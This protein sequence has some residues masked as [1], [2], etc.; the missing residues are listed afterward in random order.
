VLIE[1]TLQVISRIIES[2]DRSEQGRRYGHPILDIAREINRYIH[3]N[4]LSAG[5]SKESKMAVEE[6]LNSLL[7][8][9][10]RWE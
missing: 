3:P 10:F 9:S 5:R 8:K 7:K 4:I 2:E 6:A 1:T